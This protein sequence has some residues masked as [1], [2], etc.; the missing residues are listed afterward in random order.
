MKLFKEAESYAD[1]LQASYDYYKAYGPQTAA[2]FLAAYKDSVELLRRW[3]RICRPRRHEWRQMV[4][5]DYPN[6]SIFYKE[7]SFCW[8]LGGIVPSVSDPDAIQ[9]RLLVREVAETKT[10]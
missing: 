5:Q 8:L 2:R 7:L 3:P 6:Y 1:D 10:G 9:A 4:I